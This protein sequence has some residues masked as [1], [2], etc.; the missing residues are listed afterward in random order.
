MNGR[1]LVCFAAC[2]MAVH[3]RAATYYVATSS[4]DANAGTS[5][6]LAKQTIQA[7]IDVAV[8]NDTVLVSNGVYGTGGRVVSFGMTNRLA[9]VSNAADGAYAVV[10]NPSSTARVY[11]VFGLTNLHINPQGWSAMSG[12]QTG[13]GAALVFTVTNPAPA[14]NYHSTVG[15]P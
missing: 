14:L 5:W 8:S 1:M 10:I 12:T 7:A 3:A 2:L 13:T 11:R 15:L 9:A 6:A 4:N